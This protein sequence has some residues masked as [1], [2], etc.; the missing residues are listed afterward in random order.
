VAKVRYDAAEFLDSLF[1]PADPTPADL[2]AE[3]RVRWEER[4]GIVQFDGG[5]PRELAEHMALHDIANQRNARPQERAALTGDPETGKLV[6]RV[7][8]P[9]LFDD[10]ML[11]D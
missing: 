3:W 5:L 8:L 1:Q 4:A 2:P 6:A 9:D 7:N 11:P 10:Q